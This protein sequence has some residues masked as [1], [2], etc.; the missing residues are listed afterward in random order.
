M[1]NIYIENA[2]RDFVVFKV[3]Y[4]F[5]NEDT[6]YV[7]YMTHKQYINF[8][9]LPSIDEVTILKRNQVEMKHMRMKC[10]DQLMRRLQI[11][12]LT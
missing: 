6:S 11:V 3:M 4:K 2:F 7:C 5:L 9:D 12:L 8:K 1:I 10:N